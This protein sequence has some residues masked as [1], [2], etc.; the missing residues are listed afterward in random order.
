VVV[1]GPPSFLAQLTSLRFVAAFLVLLSH[2]D[3]LA[4]VPGTRADILY[5]TL[6]RQG[7][8]GVSFFYILSG[9]ILSHAYGDR[10]MRGTVGLRS[11][12]LSRICRIAPLHWTMSLLFIGWLALARD[13]PQPGTL[14][15]NLTLLHAWAPDANTHYAL[16]GP[17]WSLSD[18]LFFY[19]AFPWLCRTRTRPMI[20]CLGAAVLLVLTAAIVIDAIHPLYSPTI[21]WA[22]YVAPPVRLIEFVTGMLVYRAYRRNYG[23]TIAGTAAEIFTIA[24]VI[25][26]MIDFSLIALPMPFRWQLAYLPVMALLLLVFAHGQG[27]ISHALRHPYMILLGEASFALYLT[28]RP[29]ITLAQ[30]LWGGDPVNDLSMSLSLPPLCVALSLAVF[31]YFERPLLRRLRRGVQALDHDKVGLTKWRP[32]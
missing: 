18:E 2:L 23:G 24:M 32:S 5:Q 15:L 7:Y 29:V 11:Y 9:F 14:L 8:C 4:A 26:A 20:W 12:F 19:A 13:L 25:A 17:S 6:F 10:L 21:E 30:R 31:L 1:S 16:N 27:A 3:F 22:F 28:H